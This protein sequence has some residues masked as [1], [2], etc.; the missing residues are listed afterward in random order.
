MALDLVCSWG[1]TWN[2]LSLRLCLPRVG[3]TRD[4][5]KSSFRFLQT[6]I[7][8]F[9]NFYLFD[10]GFHSVCETSLKLLILASASRVLWFQARTSVPGFRVLSTLREF[11][12]KADKIFL[13]I[14]RSGRYFKKKT[15][16][17]P[18]YK[19]NGAWETI[20]LIFW[21]VPIN[22]TFFKAMLYN[23]QEARSSK[24]TNCLKKWRIANDC[25]T[26]VSDS[27][28]FI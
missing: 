3:I 13:Q 26:R 14:T 19:S 17:L 5:A 12:V 7:F 10:I 11:P 9:L 2:F 24:N 23:I 6:H 25:P 27:L 1:L 28:L 4:T 8:G 20:F 18:I 21:K 15:F 16:Y 22:R